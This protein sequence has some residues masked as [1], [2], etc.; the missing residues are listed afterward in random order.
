MRVFIAVLTIALLCLTGTTDASLTELSQ[1]RRNQQFTPDR[2][3]MGSLRGAESRRL[4]KGDD[5]GDKNDGP[6]S[7]LPVVDLN[8][9]GTLV[10]VIL[11]LVALILFCWKC[12]QC[13][14]R[15]SEGE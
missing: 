11:I 3:L 5:K 10:T 8:D 14:G 13:K 1:L 6:F 15:R 7:D 9:T 4:K 2:S 12:A